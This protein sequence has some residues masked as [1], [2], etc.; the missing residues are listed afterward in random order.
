MLDPL[1]GASGEFSTLFAG[2]HAFLAFFQERFDIS[3]HRIIQGHS[4]PGEGTSGFGCLEYENMVYVVYIWIY[5]NVQNM[6]SMI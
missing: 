1:D 4:L 3:H 6:Y 5:L 2:G